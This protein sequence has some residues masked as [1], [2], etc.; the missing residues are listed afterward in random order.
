MPTEE[1]YGNQTRRDA[2]RSAD[3][4]LRSGPR[5]PVS[6]IRGEAIEYVGDPPLPE[7]ME[8]LTDVQREA[9]PDVEHTSYAYPTVA[10]TVQSAIG[11]E[12]PE[13]AHKTYGKMAGDWAKKYDKAEESGRVAMDAS[14]EWNKSMGL[15]EWSSSEDILSLIA[16]G[17][18]RIA[19]PQIRRAAAHLMKLN[20]AAIAD[21]AA[22]DAA[23]Q[24]TAG[25]DPYFQGQHIKEEFPER[26]YHPY[27]FIR[28]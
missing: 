13:E 28:E 6:G 16:T 5:D 18:I 12:T 26:T 20:S 22:K 1:Q 10:E 21:E 4:E 8:Q 23:H 14:R 17:K 24:T 15:P 2:V 3:K 25:D 7:D 9:L 19:D 11:G 27:D